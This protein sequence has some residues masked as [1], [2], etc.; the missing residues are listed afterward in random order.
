MSDTTDIQ[1]ARN[2]Q[3]Q[4]AKQVDCRN[5]FGTINTLA[6]IDVSCAFKSAK[7]PLT[8]AIVVLAAED[9][10]VK[11]IACA[12]ILPS[13]PYIPGLLAFR[14]IPAIEA[15]LAKLSVLPDLFFVDGHGYSHP[16][17]CGIASHLGVLINKPT[18]GVAKNILIGH[19]DALP[20]TQGAQTPLFWQDEIIAMLVRSRL[21]AKPIIVSAGH[22]IDLTTSLTWVKKTLTTYRLPTPTRLAHY[23][24]N[25]ARLCPNAPFIKV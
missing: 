13:L 17:H 21:R 25:Q 7:Q 5:Q 23:Y 16:Q 18:I 8:A 2:Q 6:G 20:A 12:S 14:E 15:A 11:E 1:A 10:Q 19:A 3:K 9:L 4:L 22:H 24:S